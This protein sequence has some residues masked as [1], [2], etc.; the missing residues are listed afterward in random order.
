MSVFHPAS[1]S[2]PG[3]PTQRHQTQAAQH[4]QEIFLLSQLGNWE[5]LMAFLDPTMH[6]AAPQRV[7]VQAA[8][9]AAAEKLLKQMDPK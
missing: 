7:A 6:R 1:A 5:D 9:G 4:V 8:S 3:V 2:K